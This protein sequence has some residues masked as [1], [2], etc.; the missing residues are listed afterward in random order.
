MFK[1]VLFFMLFTAFAFTQQLPENY[2]LSAAGKFSRT[3]AHDR[4]SENGIYS[5]EFTIDSVT[6]ETRKLTD[7]IFYKN[8]II[9]YTLKDIPG[10]DLYISNSGITAFIDHTFHFRN[11]IT[12]N[13]CS[14]GGESLSPYNF[15][16]AYLFNFSPDGNIMGVGT[17][18]KLNVIFIK[19]NRTIEYPGCMS[20]AIDDNG[21]FVILADKNILSVYSGSELIYST[22]IKNYVRKIRLIDES[23]FCFIT[24]DKFTVHS[25]NINKELFSSTAEYGSSFN[26]LLFHHNKIYLG[27]GK[28]DN[29]RLASFVSE[30][31][32]LDVSLPVKVTEK[33]YSK[34]LQV[35]KEVT[36]SLYDPI[37]W[38]F[39]PF[40]KPVTVWNHYEQHMGYGTADYA[41]LH[42]GLDLIIPIQEPTYT[43]QQGIVK[44]VLTLGGNL[45]WRIAVSPVNEPGRSNG[46]LY[47]H[48][49]ESS[50]PVFTGDTVDIHEYLGDIVAWTADWGH[51]HFVEIND[52]GL[53][54]FYDD[55]EWGINFNPLLALHPLYDTIPPVIQ[56]AWEN[57]KFIYCIN[58]TSDY[59]EP[60]SLHGEIDIIIKVVDYIGDSEWQQPAFKSYYHIER[61]SD[62]YIVK[63]R[64]LGHILNHS[65]SM[66]SSTYYTP[67]AKVLYKLDELFPA[68]F[69]MNPERDYFHII[70]N[71]NGD[72]FID[73]TD[74]YLSLDTRLYEDGWYRIH[75]E[76]FDPS[77][78][79]ASDSMDVKFV[80]GVVS[81]RDETVPEYTELHQNYPNPFNPY[82]II[83]FN[84]SKPGK[85]LVKIY[86]LLGKETAVLLDDYR[87]AGFYQL[88]LNAD[89]YN[90]PSGIYFYKLVSDE[91]HSVRKLLLVK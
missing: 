77:G 15:Q 40:D 87:S 29:N 42:Q 55:N 70:T 76:V 23:S 52:S 73:S 27:V 45:Y 12:I 14:S 91:T 46:W 89:I 10:S 16:G 59:L 62:N 24:K 63:P 17:P 49:I 1:G 78:N 19:E 9:Q 54:W 34:P 67:Y 51:I 83:S 5:C 38:P 57:Y 32:D 64:E 36:D 66:Y 90:L 30:Y 7:Y 6:D 2:Q 20:F 81:L 86:D 71:N 74:R 4:I 47:A 37:P 58:E 53:V 33:N 60:D 61:L 22:P 88:E 35:R 75:V 48:L 44:G 80:N 18:G 84:L 26:D 41:Y 3:T 82:T 11:Q 13:F 56:N 8:G 69:W 68:P 85:V 39:Y 65:Y 21:S 25:L 72:E 28:R 43:V 31:K 79:M 50:I